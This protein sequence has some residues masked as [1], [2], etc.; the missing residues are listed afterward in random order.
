M[1]GDVAGRGVSRVVFDSRKV[2]P[3]TVFVAVKG[4]RTDGH[5]YIEQALQSG[6]VAIV[7]ADAGAMEEA[8]S[9]GVGEAVWVTVSDSAAALAVL[10]DEWYGRPSQDLTIVGVTGTNGKTTVTTLLHDLFTALGY[11]CGLLSTVEVRIGTT[12]DTAT[13]T[14]PDALAIHANL[15]AMRDA[16]CDYAFMEVSSHA[17]DQ[18]RVHGL[19]FAGGVFTNLSHDHL[20]YHGT[21]RAYL[22]AKKAFFDHLPK[23]AFALVNQ[24]D[25][26]GEVMLQNTKARKRRYSLRRVTDYRARVMDNGPAGLELDLDGTP[27]FSR[28]IGKFNAYNLV[29]AYAVARELGMDRDD[30]LVA[31]SSLR[32]ASGRMDHVAD[33]SG[34]VTALVDYA[35]TPD[36]LRNVLETLRDVAEATA[37]L[38]CVVGAGGDRDRAKRPEMARLAAR[39]ADQTILTSDN[40]R[41]EDPEAILNEMQAGLDSP[42][43]QAKVLR[44]TDRRSAIRTAVQLARPGDI[45]LVAGKGHENYQEIKGERLPFDDKLELSQALQTL[46]HA[47]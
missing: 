27:F 19:P 40:P 43:L 38:L 7:G 41:S 18:R 35:H 46:R 17:V 14:T 10:A 11:K 34:S 16:G 37:R 47:S 9:K 2:V 33:P 8:K 5:Q 13:H 30:T 1:T 39:L 20:D 22:E 23:S 29:A 32:A 45:V 3:G 24:D 42:E 26:N 44:I 4:T 15:A 31:L 6:A 36:A 21:F 25:R 28:L 12:V